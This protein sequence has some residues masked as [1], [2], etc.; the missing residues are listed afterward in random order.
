[1]FRILGLLLSILSRYDLIQGE[2]FNIIYFNLLNMTIVFK[3]I[4][5]TFDLVSALLIHKGEWVVDRSLWI[6]LST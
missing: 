4:I 2:T 3:W 5:L 6:L 1:M